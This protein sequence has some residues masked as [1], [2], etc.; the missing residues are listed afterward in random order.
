MYVSGFDL[1]LDIS[2]P[3]QGYRYRFTVTEQ[4]EGAKVLIEKNNNY[5]RIKLAKTMNIYSST[6]ESSLILNNQKLGAKN[7]QEFPLKQNIVRYD[8]V[9][10]NELKEQLFGKFSSAFYNSEEKTWYT[11]GFS[12]KIIL[13]KTEEGAQDKTLFVFDTYLSSS[14]PSSKIKFNSQKIVKGEGFVDDTIQ[15][16]ISFLLNDESK[17]LKSNISGE[18]PVANNG[19]YYAKLPFGPHFITGYWD[20]YE[21]VVN[22]VVPKSLDSR[23]II[24]KAWTTLSKI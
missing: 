24:D 22:G 21:H 19:K 18:I 16:D 7:I 23:L 8:D 2:S 12:S 4:E 20:G 1:G 10:Q 15:L 13:Y 6:Q 11:V 3:K 9:H 14:N 5:P 17:K